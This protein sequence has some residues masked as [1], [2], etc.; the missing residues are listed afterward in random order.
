[1]LLSFS[2]NR[3]RLDMASVGEHIDDSRSLQPEALLGDQHVQVSR[4]RRRVTGYV[5]DPGWIYSTDVPNDFNGA[6]PR[7]IQQKTVPVVG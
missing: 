4:Q 7:G 3:D 6:A 5:D 2:E 1:M